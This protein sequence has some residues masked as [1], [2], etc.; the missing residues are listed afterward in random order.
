MAIQGT[1]FTVAGTSDYPVCD[2]CGKTNLTRAVMVRNEFGEEFN[3]G[4]ICASKVLRQRY[5]GK[6]F[7]ISTAAVISMGKAAKA[8]PEWRARNGYGNHSF[9]LVAA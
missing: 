8:S 5:Q 2:C 3:V 7:K 9:Q 1:L 4:C 6:N